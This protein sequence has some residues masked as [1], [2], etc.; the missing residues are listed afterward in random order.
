MDWFYEGDLLLISRIK[1]AGGPM[2]GCAR[3]P[4]DLRSPHMTPSISAF[5]YFVPKRYV[6]LGRGLGASVTY[7]TASREGLG[8]C[9]DHDP[10]KGSFWPKQSV[11]S[12]LHSDL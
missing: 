3:F 1:E 4:T 8:H 12:R 9:D 5:Q 11:L 6:L 7:V 2:C 10:Q